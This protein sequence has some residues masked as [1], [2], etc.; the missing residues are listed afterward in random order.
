M[1]FAADEKALAM[2]TAYKAL[3]VAL[4]ESGA[5]DPDAFA[6]QSEMGVA[7]LT[8]V[9]ETGA[10]SALAEILEPLN[11]EVRQWRGGKDDHQS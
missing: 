1:R 9:G 10:A 4:L 6:L 3:V 2:V 11:A 8:R 5:L 7:W